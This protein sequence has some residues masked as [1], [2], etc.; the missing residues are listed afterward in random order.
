VLST[1]V[2]LRWTV[3]VLVLLIAISVFP[4]SA[5]AQHGIAISGYYPVG[6]NGDMFTGEL[7]PTNTGDQVKLV[8]K[9]GNTTESFAG[10]IDAPCHAP[11]KNNPREQKEMHLTAIPAGTKLTA[12]Y[13]ATAEKQDG[14][15]VH[16]N[17]I[18]KLRFDSLN[19]K[20]LTSPSRPIIVCSQAQSM[21]FHA[22]N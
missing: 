22:F 14:K 10:T 4:V 19:G 6:Y 15:K 11:L 5:H 8:Y 2:R 16:V 7:V 20:A 9:D 12:Y 3:A 21:P 17:A 1:S 13:I 18:W